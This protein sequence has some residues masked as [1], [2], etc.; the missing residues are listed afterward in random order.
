MV[1]EE[2]H[3]LLEEEH[4][5]NGKGSTWLHEAAAN[6]KLKATRAILEVLEKND[7]A[8]VLKRRDEYD[9]YFLH[10]ALRSTKVDKDDILNYINKLDDEVIQT[11]VEDEKEHFDMTIEEE[12]NHFGT[13]EKR[14]DFERKC[15]D[16]LLH[17]T[18]NHDYYQVVEKLH[19][20]IAKL[21]KIKEDTDGSDETR[22]ENQE[23]QENS[24]QEEQSKGT[25]VK[26]AQQ[27][28]AQ[29]KHATGSSCCC[30]IKGICNA[31]KDCRHFQRN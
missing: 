28:Y 1:K 27:K 8:E 23:H 2:N 4:F 15:H 21:E 16:S 31:K 12:K 11:I 18:T 3:D 17:V 24:V 14:Y 9:D 29:Q 10:S 13:G 30:K 26:Y 5:M 25:K 20:V 22:N 7:K 19:K 6:G